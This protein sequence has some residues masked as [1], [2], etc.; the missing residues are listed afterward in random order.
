MANWI[1][2][3]VGTGSLIGQFLFGGTAVY[4]LL[5]LLPRRK[6]RWKRLAFLSWRTKEAPRNWVKWLAIHIERPADQERALLLAGC[7]VTADPAWY[8]LAR[9]FVVIL[10]LVV[11]GGA[12]LL[13]RSILLSPQMQ[14]MTGMPI[15]LM[16]ALGLDRVWLRAF[17]KLRKL[18]IT[19]EIYMISN[20]LLYLSESSLHIHAKLMRCVPFTRMMRGE[21]EGLLADWYH[22]PAIALKVFKSRLGTDEGMSFVETIDALRQHES[23]HY[24]EL[25]R[26]RI[27]DYKEKLEIAKLSRKESTSYLLFVL[28]GVPILYTFQIFIYPWV[29]EGQK[30]FQ[31]LS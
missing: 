15:L 21:L 6:T 24:Y 25:L 5:Q 7:G 13:S 29:R 17:H 28:A 10:L 2:A 1:E 31:A 8:L 20:Q 11:A 4:L 14:I 30:L 19:K 26:V 16:I 23:S 27:S 22:D 9:R 3:M 12:A 18:Q